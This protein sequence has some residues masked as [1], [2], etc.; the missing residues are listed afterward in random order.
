MPSDT[1]GNYTLPSGYKATAQFTATAAQHNTPLE[2]IAANLSARLAVNGSNAMTGP[3]R[4]SGDPTDTLHATPRGWVLSQI[5]SSAPATQQKATAVCATTAN[6]T[7]SGEQTID[8]V[9]TTL[10]RVL[11][12]DQ[13]VPAQNGVYVSGAGSWTRASDFDVWDDVVSASLWV[14]SGTVNGATQWYC[15]SQIGGTIGTTPVTFLQASGAG[16]FSAVYQPLNSKLTSLAGVAVVAG[17]VLVGSGT[18]TFDRVGIGGPS[19][20]FQ[21]NGATAS[22]GAL[23]YATTAEQIALTAGRIV[24]PSTQGAHR[25]A[26]KAYCR[27]ASGGATINSFGF[28]SATRLSAGYYRLAYPSSLTPNEVAPTVTV[29]GG[30]AMTA[31]FGSVAPGQLDVSLNLVGGTPVPSDSFTDFT[32]HLAGY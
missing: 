1:A 13:T 19:T 24:Q 3:L 23:P 20:F 7:L 21:S 22:F 14:R 25:S 5:A 17:D 28:T 2:D 10:S 6:I 16:T 9:T 31:Q 4:L 12:K 30:L 27:I 32:V 18:G 26:L 11:V 15:N 29:N 8:G